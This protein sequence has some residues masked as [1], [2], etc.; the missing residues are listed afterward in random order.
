MPGKKNQ[1]ADALSRRGVA[2]AITLVRS[3]LPD[4]IL[5]KINTDTL[6]G[7]LILEIQSQREHRS[8]EDC[9]W[10]EGLLYF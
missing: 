5:Q 9:T 2:L 7:P 4:K 6:F 1:V 8:L 10:K 3:S